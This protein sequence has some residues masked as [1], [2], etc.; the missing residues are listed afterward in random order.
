[1]VVT[2][3]GDA[4]R[5][6]DDIMNLERVLMPRDKQRFQNVYQIYGLLEGSVSRPC[7]SAQRIS[8]HSGL[9]MLAMRTAA[10]APHDR[11]CPHA[12][13]S[14]YSATHVSV[15]M[16]RYKADQNITAAQAEQLK[17]HIFQLIRGLHYMHSGAPLP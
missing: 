3:H 6:A 15:Q 1:M 5:C 11:D 8:G 14:H 7:R 16:P 13:M 12:R 10:L 4:L 17:L 2:L 9:Q